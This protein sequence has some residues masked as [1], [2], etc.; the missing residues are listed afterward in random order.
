ME[1]HWIYYR[2]FLRDPED[3]DQFRTLLTDVV[4][5]IWELYQDRITCLYFLHYTGPYHML[6]EGG[7]VRERLPGVI[8]TSKV[9]FIRL[10][11]RAID[12]PSAKL[13]RE[14]LRKLMIE[15]SDAILGYEVPKIPYN[16]EEDLGKRFDTTPTET[17]LMLL[18]IATMISLHFAIIPEKAISYSSIAND[19]GPHAIVHLVANILDT[20]INPVFNV[21][22]FGT[23][24][25]TRPFA[26][27][28]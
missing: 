10:R 26:D 5:P 11:I 15:H 2:I 9:R 4:S 27:L 20:H 17:L 21:Y 19:G 6:A 1:G 8:S 24:K 16:P 3:F 23:S 7:G 18:E 25:Q 22:E 12:R 13:I 28:L 14:R